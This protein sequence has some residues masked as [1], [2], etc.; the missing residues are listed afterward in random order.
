M[1]RPNVLLI[2]LDHWPARVMS[3]LGHP[4]VQTPTLDQMAQNG[5]LFTRAYSPTPMCM[6]ARRE[7]F[8]GMTAR[9][10]GD[11]DFLDIPFP[12]HPRMP[13]V[14]RDAGYQAYAVGKMHVCPQRDRIGFD[15][16]ILCEEGRHQYGEG[17][18]DYELFLAEQGF[19]GQEL[20]HGMCNNEYSVRPWHL[21]ERCHPTNWTT[22]EACKMIRRRDPT[23]PAF[24]YVSYQHPHPPLAP[25]QAYLDL[26]RDV[27]IPMPFIGEWARDEA[28]VPYALWDRRPWRGQYNE[29]AIR[30]ARRAFFAQCT[31]IDHQIRLILGLLREFGLL[32]NT[33][34]ALTCDHGDML[35]NH[36]LWHK[37]VF[38]EDSARI[39]L[40]LLPA[41]RDLRTPIGRRD[42]RLAALCDV[43]PTLL[44][45]CDIPVPAEVEGLSLVGPKRRE[46]IYGEH[47]TGPLATRMVRDARYKLIYYAVGNRFQLF[48]LDEDPDELRD[49]ADL[50]ALAHVRQRLTESLLRNLY[51]TDRE[52]IR[53]GQIVGKPDLPRKHR[54]VHAYNG[55]RGWRFM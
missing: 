27:E 55:Q 46:E 14:F 2:C 1:S 28:A 35:G 11:R 12:R 13:Q 16:V 32:D 7:L 36:H 23:R 6:T 53:D 54:A 21:P 40:L 38:Y 33:V 37:G 51:G 19:P 42:D 4:A 15:D 47:F 50:P 30:M 41:A 48:D 39:P 43:M 34:I 5:V 17:A 49:L 31:H 3:G 45:F 26:Y 10:H 25:L 22:Y 52:W 8:T 29:G 20:T 24:W 9:N 18:D 44:E